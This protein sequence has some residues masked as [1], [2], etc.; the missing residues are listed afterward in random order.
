MP[1]E[2]RFWG[3][4]FTNTGFNELEKEFKSYFG[5]GAFGAYLVCKDVDMSHQ[6]L[7]RIL[8]DSSESDEPP[9]DQPFEIEFF[10]PYHYIKIIAS[11]AERKQIGFL[12]N[13]K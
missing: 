9:D 6:Y 8:V 13:K 2:K 12:V 7:L 5:E 1:K 11:S 10:V 3:I 4:L